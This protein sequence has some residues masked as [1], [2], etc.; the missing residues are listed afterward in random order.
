VRAPRRLLAGLTLV[1][2]LVALAVGL[3]LIAATTTFV[4][5]QLRQQRQRLSDARLDLALLRVA[6]L[7]A[8]DLRRA[9]HWGQADQAWMSGDDSRH[10]NPHAALLPPGPD[11]HGGLPAWSYGRSNLDHPALQDDAGRDADETSALR[12]NPS[13]HAIDLRLSG[14]ALAPGSGDTWQ[15][16]TDPQRLRLTLWRVSRSD[17]VIDLLAHCPQPVCP[18][19]DTACPPQRVIRLLSIEL[20]G[21]D[22][23]APDR[24]RQLRRF[25][26]VRNDE[27]RGHC[28]PA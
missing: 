26:R 22:P 23:T 8:R 13:T 10:A 25:V 9:G 17:R 5:G 24:S 7:A 20:A 3:V 27:L 16:L 12:L 28:P 21:H 18:A 4:L 15:A 11:G 2:L 6:D 14:P 19:G 1:E